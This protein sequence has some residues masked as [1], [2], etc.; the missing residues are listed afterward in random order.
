MV[1]D[2]PA[3]MP[4]PGQVI[5]Q[6]AVSCISV[7]TEM[8]GLRASSRPIWKRA[9]DNPENVIKALRRASVAPSR[10]YKDSLGLV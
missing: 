6:T 9:I 1:E 4:V 7:G 10:Q 5:V 8:S 2:I 3:L